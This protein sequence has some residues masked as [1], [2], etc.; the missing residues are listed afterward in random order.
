M[1]D[2]LIKYIGFKYSSFLLYGLI[3]DYPYA[4]D[5]DGNYIPN[6]ITDATHD[7]SLMNWTYTV[8][9]GVYWSDNTL[10][11]AEDV[12]FTSNY[13]SQNLFHLWHYAPDLNQAVQC[14]GTNKGH[15]GVAISSTDPWNV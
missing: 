4:F 1:S 2:R 11:T 13:D 7:S 6:I 3:Y 10:L 14:T 8:R 15:C 9:Q 5:Q 12:A